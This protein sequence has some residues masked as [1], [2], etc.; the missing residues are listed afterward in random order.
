MPGQTV[1]ILSKLDL[2]TISVVNLYMGAHKLTGNNWH[3]NIAEVKAERPKPLYAFS[4][5]LLA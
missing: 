4:F 2:G 1:A 3:V 5:G